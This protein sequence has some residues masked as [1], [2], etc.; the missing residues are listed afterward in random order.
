MRVFLSVL[1]IVPHAGAI[2]NTRSGAYNSRAKRL[3]Y[4]GEVMRVLI[5]GRNGQVARELQRSCASIS[6]MRAIGSD[7][8]NLKDE[9][10]IA[11]A[12]REFKPSHIVNAAAYTAVDKAE[13]E[14]E[15][16]FKI[17][18][19]ALGVMGEEAK[20]IQ[21]HIVHYSTDYVFDGTQKTPY[22]ETD[23][24]QPVNAY[25]ESKLQ[26][27]HL[28]AQSGAEHVILRVSW[29]YGLY[30][31]N[32]LKTMLR[33]GAEREELSVVAD[34]VGVPT[35]SRHIA[36]ATAH[37]LRDPNLHSKSGVYHLTPQG[38]TTWHGFAS[39]IFELAADK[40]KLKV[41]SVHPIKT[42]QFPTPAKRPA[43]SLMNSDKVQK[44]FG[45]RLPQW[46]ESLT[47]LMQDRAL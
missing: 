6:E 22:L 4:Q 8:V 24:T 21:A 42:E 16:A 1:R 31:H 19:H 2:E 35:W 29:V 47:M 7:Q 17:N 12:I 45:V 13:Q 11:K 28:L 14:R 15:L 9:S 26:G 34:Q 25:G 39:R 20:K 38:Q 10:A 40:E 43:S 46:D 27:E 5:F 36:D 23:L 32:F 30:G 37:I 3:F 33:L 18:G 44:V 41:Q